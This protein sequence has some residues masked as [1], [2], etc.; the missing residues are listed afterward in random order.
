VVSR[1]PDTEQGGLGSAAGPAGSSEVEVALRAFSAGRIVVISDGEDRENEADL[2]MAAEA[3]DE[4]SIGFIVRHTGGVLCVPMSGERAVRLGLAPMVEANK[5]PH[6]TAFTVSVDHV[7]TGTGISA[8]DRAATIR[9]L[10]DPR[11]QADGFR[12]PG[13]VFPLVARAGGV[14]KRAGHTEAALDL[15][16]MAETEQVAVIS[17]LV[18]D[19]GQ[20]LAYGDA[21]RFAAEHGLVHITIADLQRFR[22]TH[23]SLVERGGESSLPTEHGV[24]RARAYR[25]LL[26]GTEH[27]A[28]TLGD[29]AWSDDQSSVLVRMHSECLTGDVLRSE[30]CDCGAQ[31]NEALRLIGEE[32]RGALVYLRGQE[33]RGIGLSH[34]LHAYALQDQGYDT[35]DANVELGLPVDSREYG[36]GAHILADLGVRRIRLLT[37]NPAKYTGL[38]GYDLEI[39]ER[40]ALRTVPIASNLQYL[41][42]KQHRLGHDLGLAAAATTAFIS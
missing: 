33:G 27:L 6:R 30:R 18:S 21:A 35:V 5:D 23:E 28:L 40:V 42:T 16:R 29:V 10:A 11:A 1:V 24:F 19:G 3:V 41:S 7:S 31:L 38:V 14:L 9:A 17:E 8:A 22:R 36:V 26:D 13:H 2:V 37:N 20:P 12:R 34:K 4:A 32:G 15:T 39:T 25:S